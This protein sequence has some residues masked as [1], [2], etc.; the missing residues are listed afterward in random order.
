M[1]KLRRICR[2]KISHWEPAAPAALRII[3]GERERAL[4]N[5]TLTSGCPGAFPKKRPAHG[6]AALRLLLRLLLWAVAIIAIGLI[7]AAA[8]PRLLAG[9]AASPSLTAEPSL[10]LGR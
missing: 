8:W 2:S 4:T 3:G 10:V 6:S 1:S 5:Q 9:E 7:A